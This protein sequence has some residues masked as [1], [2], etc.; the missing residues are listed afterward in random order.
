MHA[1]EWK[2]SLPTAALSEERLS[3]LSCWMTPL[4]L[5]V[6]ETPDA[7]LSCVSWL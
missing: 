4:N 7:R 5:S 2:S 6:S 1:R 3:S